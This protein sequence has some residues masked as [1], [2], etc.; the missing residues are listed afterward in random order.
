ME[1]ATPTGKK[2][3][4]DP[5]FVETVQKRSGKELQQCYQC[6]KCSVGCP[7]AFV[8]DYTPNQIIRMVQLGLREK[9]LS[10]ATIWLCAA[11]EACSTRCPNDVDIPVFMEVLKQM[12][13]EA[14]I[15]SKASHIPTF[16]KVFLN[17]I[18]EYGRLHEISLLAAYKVM[19]LNFHRSDM[20][21]GFL[22]FM[23]GKLSIL[24]TR[25]KNISEIEKIFTI[26]GDKKKR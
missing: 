26:F 21:L 16:H 11:C 9:V 8:M 24:P 23:K 5:N 2:E 14:G 25:I 3:V 22:M 17:C 13:S 18:R 19:S 15:K 7:V 10:S 1:V 6:F 20:P 12:G 4:V